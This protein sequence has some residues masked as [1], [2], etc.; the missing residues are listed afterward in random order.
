MGQYHKVYNIDR[1]EFIHPHSIDCGLKLVEQMGFSGSTADALFL[2]VANSNG[3]G[4]GDV[5]DH[6]M[7]GR[8]AG[9]RVVV[10]GDYSEV[11]D[12]AHITKSELEGY[13]DISSSVLE[14]LKI[15]GRKV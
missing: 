7:I 15:T 3:R 1:K 4:G 12:K 2:L 5:V 9:D 8:W 14:M 10:Q 11:N 13:R 6:P